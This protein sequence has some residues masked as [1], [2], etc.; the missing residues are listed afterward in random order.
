MQ[1]TRQ[2]DTRILLCVPV[3][4]EFQANK[5]AYEIEGYVSRDPAPPW[6]IRVMPLPYDGMSVAKGM[7]WVTSTDP[8]VGWIQ[9][10]PC[11]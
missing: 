11:P 1:V 3:Q 6:A 10:G 8:H 5:V 9:G 7:W 4:D 2:D